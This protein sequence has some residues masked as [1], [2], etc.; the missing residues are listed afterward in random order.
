M[1]AIL[2]SVSALATPELVGQVGKLA[3]IDPSLVA[4]GW[5]AV[6]PTVLGAL[7]AKAAA[8][9]GADAISS[10]LKMVGEDAAANPM[11]ALSSLAGGGMGTDVVSGL[12]GGQATSITNSLSRSIGIP[13]LGGLM[14]V[15]APLMISQIA[16]MAKDKNLDAKAVAKE[17]EAEAKEL[18]KSDDPNVKAAMNAF[19]AADAQDAMKAKVGE[20]GWQALTVA[21]ALAAS[22][23][24]AAGK[25]GFINDPMGAAKEAKALAASFDPAN[26]PAGSVL[27]DGVANSLQDAVAEAAGG[28]LPWDLSDLDLSDPAQVKSG[29][30]DKLLAARD[31][32]SALPAD[33]QAK[34]KQA[35]L[36]GVTRVAESSKEG[37]FLG[38]GGKLVSDGEVVA[39]NNV[40]RS[41][42]I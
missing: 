17:I 35:V 26:L 28:N 25:G 14:K 36:D 29:I 12:L 33:E 21:P 31:A 9:G 7:G 41:L 39:I 38:I 34:Y 40:K 18:A 42:G 23:V 22:Y 20:K 16:K 32:L 27:V 11:G 24:A 30:Q 10:M 2:D 15:G 6:G 8:P 37:G 3:G 4:T 1:S 5:K 13:G 19:K